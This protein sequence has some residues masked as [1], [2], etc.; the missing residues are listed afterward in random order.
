MDFFLAGLK[1]GYSSIDLILSGFYKMI[2]IIKS[3][4]W[5]DVLCGRQLKHRAFEK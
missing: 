1:L 4:A 2:G 3:S 5:H